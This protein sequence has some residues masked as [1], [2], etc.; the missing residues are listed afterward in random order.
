MQVVTLVSPW[1][2]QEILRSGCLAYCSVEGYGNSAVTRSFKPGGSRRARISR[3][4]PG[5]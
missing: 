3:T 1:G 4:S 5:R 2:T